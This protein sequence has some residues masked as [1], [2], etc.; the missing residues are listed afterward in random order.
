MVL[1]GSVGTARRAFARRG[2]ASA[3]ADW[4]FLLLAVGNKVVEMGFCVQRQRDAVRF[5]VTSRATL[6]AVARQ[7]V[8]GLGHWVCALHAVV[9]INISLLATYNNCFI[10]CS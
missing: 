9:R 5:C 4:T 10:G 3:T 7:G 6:V 1:C 2:W 8:A